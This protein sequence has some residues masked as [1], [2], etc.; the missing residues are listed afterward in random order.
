M[1]RTYSREEVD[2]ILRRAAARARSSGEPM[3]TRDELVDA[4]REAGI[5]PSAVHQAADEVEIGLAAPVRLP[6]EEEAVGAWSRAGV[7]ASRVT[8]SRGWSSAPGSWS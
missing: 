2:E 3:L 6:T 5:D 7:E 4:A 1:S 8:C